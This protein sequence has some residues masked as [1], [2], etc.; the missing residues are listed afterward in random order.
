MDLSRFQQQLSGT[1]DASQSLPPVEKWDPDFCGDLNMVIALD[2]R[3]FYE[4]S[5]IGRQSLVRLFSTVLKKE[6]ENYYLV[7]PVEKVGIQVED[8]PFVITN[9]RREDGNLILTTQTGDDCVI[10]HDHPIELRSPPAPLADPDATPIPYVN[11]RRNLWGR[12]HQNVYYQLLEHAE[13]STDEAG[14]S[15]W[16]VTSQGES[17]CIGQVK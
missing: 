2:G 14:V 1:Q 4:N 15:T 7:T 8:V 12:L 11:V 9:W 17:Y 16:T 13:S 6:D 3:W 10:G 5:P